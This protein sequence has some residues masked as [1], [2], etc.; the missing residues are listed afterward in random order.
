MLAV[1]FGPPKWRGE[2]RLLSRLFEWYSVYRLVY[3]PWL[4]RRVT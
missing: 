1:V 4:L 2:G 3:A